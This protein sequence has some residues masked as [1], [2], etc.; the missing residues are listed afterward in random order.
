MESNNKVIYIT[1][2]YENLESLFKSPIPPNEKERYDTVLFLQ[3]KMTSLMIL[4]LKEAQMDQNEMMKRFIE[5]TGMSV[6][7]A[8]QWTEEINQFFKSNKL[9]SN[10][11][12][13]TY[14][15]ILNRLTNK[16]DLLPKSGFF[17]TRSEIAKNWLKS[18]ID[19]A[20]YQAEQME[21]DFFNV[22]S[23]NLWRY[24]LTYHNDI[25]FIRKSETE[26]DAGFRIIVELNEIVKTRAHL[27]SKYSK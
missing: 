9:N 13:V 7:T 5:F 15:N 4:P 27:I 10:E 14:I 22:W 26:N 16:L 6:K 11:K 2:P 25:F 17:C 19:H 8:Y 1:Q 12:L 21:L 18:F 3:L 24:L 20:G 23:Q